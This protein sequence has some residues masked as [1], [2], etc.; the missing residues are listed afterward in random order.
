MLKIKIIKQGKKNSSFYHV[1]K[2]DSRKINSKK[3]EK[4]G[5]I[6][7]IN[8][9]IFLKLSKIN[10]Y[11]KYGARFSKG[12]KKIIKMVNKNNKKYDIKILQ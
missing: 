4:L 12:F 8:K 9:K 1:K 3:S 7:R 6:D 2:I 5:F 10:N 11:K